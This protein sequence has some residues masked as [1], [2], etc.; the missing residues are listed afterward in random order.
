MKTYWFLFW[1]YNVIWAG[2]A[3]FCLLLILRLRRVGRRLDGLEDEIARLQGQT[4]E[5]SGS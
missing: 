2:L 4:Q 1:A 5:S 3:A